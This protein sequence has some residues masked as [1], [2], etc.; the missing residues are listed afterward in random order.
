ML[1]GAVSDSDKKVFGELAHLLTEKNAGMYSGTL[2]TAALSGIETEARNL[3]TKIEFLPPGDCPPK[4]RLRY[5]QLNFVR[6]FVEVDDAISEIRRA[7]YEGTLPVPGFQQTIIEGNLIQPLGRSDTAWLHHSEWCM[8]PAA[9]FILSPAGYSNVSLLEPLVALDAPYYRDLSHFLRDQFGVKTSNAYGYF[10]GQ[11]VI[12]VPDF[13]ARISNL[14]IGSGYIK[15]EVES[16]FQESRG[17]VAKLYVENEQKVL[18]EGNVP[19]KGSD[20]YQ[21]LEDQP[22]HASVVILSRSTGEPLDQ[23]TFRGSA[24]MNDLGVKFE[25]PELEI[26]QLLLIG[27][28]ETI[29]FRE[30][31]DNAIRLAKTVCAFANTKGGRIV[32]GV[33]DEHIVVGCK[34]AGLSDRITNIVRCHCDPPPNFTV[35]SLGYEGKQILV[36]RV[37]ASDSVIHTVREHGPYIRANGTTRVPVSFELE[38]LCRRRCADG[39]VPPYLSDLGPE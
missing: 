38:Q 4:S 17:L 11:I 19:V 23:K 5:K 35:K 16:R 30:N 31:V 37:D 34:T 8:W 33:T 26:D 22:T 2:I 29:E 24:S 27:E 9:I 15:A 36:V 7:V 25:E 32:I 1:A 10:S 28:S 12:I 14:T 3:L 21:Q 39:V 6:T 13:R 20:I 18:F